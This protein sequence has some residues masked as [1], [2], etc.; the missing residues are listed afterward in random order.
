MP[1][2]KGGCFLSGGR[3]LSALTDHAEISLWRGQMLVP[4]RPVHSAD[5]RQVPVHREYASLTVK[6]SAQ[7]WIRKAKKLLVC[8]VKLL[9]LSDKFIFN[10]IVLLSF[11]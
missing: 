11:F 10:N 3:A 8:K 1:A 2:R 4:E 6:L 9:A 5:R 7:V